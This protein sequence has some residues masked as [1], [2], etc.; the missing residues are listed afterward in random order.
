[1]AAVAGSTMVGRAGK[2][3]VPPILEWR[4]ELPSDM[5]RER[6]EQ[7]STDGLGLVSCEIR[8]TEDIVKARQ[9]GSLLAAKLDFSESQITLVMTAISELGRNILLYAEVGRILLSLPDNPRRRL[10]ITAI[11]HGPGIADL[12]RAVAGGYST[13]GGFGMGLC[14]LKHIMDSFEIS[15]A[16]NRGTRVAVSVGV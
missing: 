16:L 15:S 10:I 7:P 3:A 6:V 2:A 5:E 4:A 9:I 13:S 1:M 8:Q 12:G 14:G 11:D